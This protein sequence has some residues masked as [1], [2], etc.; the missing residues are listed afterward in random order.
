MPKYSMFL[1]HVDAYQ[2]SSSAVMSTE[3]YKKALS[4]RLPAFFS[5]VKGHIINYEVKNVK[6]SV[7]TASYNFNSFTTQDK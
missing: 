7:N 5:T 1:K 4:R 3:Y 6:Q 2:L